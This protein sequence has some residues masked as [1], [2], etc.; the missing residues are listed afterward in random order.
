MLRLGTDGRGHAELHLR[1]R[2]GDALLEA[3]LAEDGAG[4]VRVALGGTLEGAR[5]ER[6]AGAL[7]ASGHDAAIDPRAGDEECPGDRQDRR[8]DS[9]RQGDHETRARPVRPATRIDRRL[10]ALPGRSPT[11]TRLGPGRGYVT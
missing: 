3:R 2:C 5:L 7:A 6:L 10:D 1:V 11:P 9:G 4:G 8:P